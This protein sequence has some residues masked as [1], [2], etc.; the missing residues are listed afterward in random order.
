MNLTAEQVEQFTYTQAKTTLATLKDLIDIDLEYNKLSET[1]RAQAD[2]WINSLLYLE[3]QVAKYDSNRF[4]TYVKDIDTEDMTDEEIERAFA[5]AEAAEARAQAEESDEKPKR[6][7]ARRNQGFRTPQ[8]HYNSI[9][10]AAKILGINKGTLQNY[11]SQGKP[12][13]GYTDPAV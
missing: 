7:R 5:A 2:L 6:R 12:G 1:H 3:D 4:Q 8:G 10:E 11:A 9:A 13:Y